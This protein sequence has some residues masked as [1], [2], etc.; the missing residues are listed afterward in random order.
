[1]P[2]D[3]HIVKGLVTEWLTLVY[4]LQ[5]LSVEGSYSLG[6]TPATVPGPC[7]RPLSSH[8]PFHCADH[9][10]PS[11]L[12]NPCW[13]PITAPP[14][15]EGPFQSTNAAQIRAASPRHPPHCPVTCPA[16]TSPSLSQVATHLHPCRHPGQPAHLGILQQVLEAS[17]SDGAVAGVLPAQRLL[18]LPQ[19]FLGF[20]HI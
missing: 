1:M 9:Q 18:Q 3:S 14:P 17:D 11:C 8:T 16:C 2:I 13:P 6:Q 12:P 5:G 4:S 15:V 10:T 20:P 19:L 7:H